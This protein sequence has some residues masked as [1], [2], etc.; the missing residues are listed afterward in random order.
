MV[1]K[2]KDEPQRGNGIIWAPLPVMGVTLAT[3]VRGAI[4]S[5]VW[6]SKRASFGAD[7]GIQETSFLGIPT[8]PFR[9]HSRRHYKRRFQMPFGV[10]SSQNAIEDAILA[11][12]PI[13]DIVW[14]RPL[15][16]TS[17]GAERMIWLQGTLGLLG[18]SIYIMY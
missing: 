18:Y 14:R 16:T 8:T 17:F 13:D 12:S 4:L 10:T 3:P 2:D 7:S 1:S 11:S 5:P 9:R 6:C 15:S